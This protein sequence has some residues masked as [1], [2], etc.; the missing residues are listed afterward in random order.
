MDGAALIV[1][2]GEDGL[3]D[4]GSEGL[5]GQGDG[6][7]VLYGGQLREVLRVDAHEVELTHAAG[8]VDF[9]VFFLK[10]Q[11]VVG[12]FPDDFAEQP[13]GEDHGTGFRHFPLEAGA[14]AG[15]LVVPGEEDVAGFLRFQKQAF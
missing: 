4:H 3:A 5:L 8:D 9:Q 2:D 10:E 7:L 12:H 11:D 14:D 6:V 15:F 1:A 13:G